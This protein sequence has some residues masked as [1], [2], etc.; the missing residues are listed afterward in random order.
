MAGSQYAVDDSE[1][2]RTQ[3]PSGH[4]QLLVNNSDGSAASITSGSMRTHLAN[5]TVTGTVVA[6]AG[7]VSFSVF[8]HARR[9]LIV[10][11]LSGLVVD[12]GH[13]QLV[14]VPEPAIASRLTY[15]G[16]PEHGTY[17]PN[18]PA[19]CGATICTQKLLAGGS[20]ATA[21]VQPSKHLMLATITN[22]V[23]ANV[24]QAVSAPH[25][26]NALLSKQAPLPLSQLSAE[27]AAWWLRRYTS[28][29]FLSFDHM[30]A[31]SFYWQQIHK[32]AAATR[33]INGST[34]DGMLDGQDNCWAYNLL[35][36]WYTP[37]RWN[38][39]H[40]DL[41]TQFAHWA[42]LP[43]NLLNSGESLVVMLER[44]MR[45]LIDNVAPRLRND[46]AAIYS[47]VGW[48]LRSQ[49]GQEISPPNE[50]GD[51]TWVSHNMW[52]QYRYSMDR[53]VLSRVG[54][55][56]LRRTANFH[57]HFAG[58]SDPSRTLRDGRLHTPLCGSPEC[59][60]PPGAVER[61]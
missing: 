13:T 52:L 11:E 56:L 41:N 37:T 1:Y 61:P 3:M 38:D 31:E 58:A 2:D 50:L 33:C 6:T 34:P 44:Q 25:Q 14:F 15:H 26:A 7:A 23:P 4:F 51:L 28:A 57:A 19:V 55:D 18:P 32:V 21:W 8:V 16:K 42:V 12:A 29:A 54:W 49:A 24:A 59:P 47:Q 40:W 60:R 10:I 48:D 22:D 35:G 45:G 30:R 43:T 17:Q 46:S 20:F 27:H 36:P 53:G 5:A 39:Y 9:H